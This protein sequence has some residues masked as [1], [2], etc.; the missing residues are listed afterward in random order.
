MAVSVGSGDSLKNLVEGT[1]NLGFDEMDAAS[2]VV[3]SANVVLPISH[4]L[5]PSLKLVVFVN[6]VIIFCSPMIIFAQGNSTLG[7]SHTYSVE[8]CQEHRVSARW[9]KD[10]VGV[11]LEAGADRRQQSETKDHG[12]ISVQ[13]YPG[14]E[15]TLSVEA[16]VE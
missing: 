9:N 3:S 10:K 16:Q 7:D 2:S 15:V 11:T 5:S 6:E 8:P 14:E 4:L 13:V 1:R 12:V